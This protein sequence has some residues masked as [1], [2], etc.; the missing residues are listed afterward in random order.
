M[1]GTWS[2]ILFHKW[3]PRISSPGRYRPCRPGRPASYVRYQIAI[4]IDVEV[5]MLPFTAAQSDRAVA[6][7]G[8]MDDQVGREYGFR[9]QD[10]GRAGTIRTTG[11][12]DQRRR[13]QVQSPERRSRIRFLIRCDGQSG[14][15]GMH[16]Q[17]APRVIVWPFLF[18]SQKPDRSHPGSG[19]PYRTSIGMDPSRNVF[20]PGQELPGN[21]V[22]LII[23]GQS[24]S[25]SNTGEA[26]SG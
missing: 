5:Q 16:P 12:V 25:R 2:I 3:A 4:D 8:M 17:R 6:P 19:K 11:T 13:G 14:I 20:I 18:V 1:P 22:G 21:Q 24:L 7:G 26:T 15:M 10:A 23:P 9:V